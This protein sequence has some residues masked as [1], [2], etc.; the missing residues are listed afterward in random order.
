MIKTLE[1]IEAEL[2]QELSEGSL[3]VEAQKRGILL[4]R[5][6]ELA[7]KSPDKVA[8]VVRLWLSEK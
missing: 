7:Q 1:E 2:S 6:N 8:E 4:K 5:V 3:T